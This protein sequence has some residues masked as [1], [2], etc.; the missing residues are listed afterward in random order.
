[1]W[2]IAPK[3]ERETLLPLA[4]TFTG[5]AELYGS[6]MLKVLEQ[7]PLTC[8]QNLSDMHQNRKAWIGHAACCLAIGCPED[9]TRAAWGLLTEQQQI[10]ANA[11]AQTAIELWETKYEG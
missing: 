10:D 3:P 9:V 2:R 5:D 7:W 1:M 11:K 6:Y 4:V 8:E